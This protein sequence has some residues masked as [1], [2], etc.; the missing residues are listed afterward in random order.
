MIKKECIFCN[1]TF[2]I[3]SYRKSTANF[4]S[5]KCYNT[6]RKKKAYPTK[7]CPYCNNMFCVNRKTRYH[8]YCSVECSILGRRKYKR[9]EKVCPFCNKKFMPSSKNINQKY[10]S[11]LCNVRSRAY[12][13]NEDVFQKIDSQEKAYLLGIIFSDGC[14]FNKR[15][16][17]ISSKDEEL[18]HW[19]K[20]IIESSAPI[21]KYKNYFSFI[22]SNK[23]IYG[24]LQK[25][26]VIE[27]KSWEEYSL[28]KIRN[29]LKRHFIRGIFDGDGSFYIDNREKYKY[30]CASFTCNSKKF[31]KEI[32]DW[33]EKRGITTQNIRFDEKDSNK[34]SWQ[35]RIS[36]KNSIRKFGNNLYRKANFFLPRK[37]RIFNSFYK[38]PS[39]SYAKQI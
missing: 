3:H 39:K 34:G 20:N 23:S 1:K 31:L 30:L 2:S 16:L 15:C 38:N 17:N 13:C 6:D 26:G 10:C 35:L 14:I 7:T 24:S 8:K 25:L 18:I 33:L 12:K 21:H 5:R 32:R 11:I 4:C 37:Y 22:I 27:R 36:K 9:E 29:N 28:P 19:C